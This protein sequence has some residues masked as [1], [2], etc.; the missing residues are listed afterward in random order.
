MGYRRRP[1]RHGHLAI[2]VWGFTDP[3]GRV[4]D[5]HG[6]TDLKDTPANRAR[7]AV[8]VACIRAEIKAK[9][10]DYLHWFPNGNKGDFFRP[11]TATAREITV[12]EYAETWLAGKAAD[13][14]N[15]RTLV[16]DYRRHL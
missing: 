10:F 6:G 3:Q 2:R 12:A 5:S 14:D 8:D 15:R 1:N 11:A 7:L 16:R 13:K 4:L 9:R